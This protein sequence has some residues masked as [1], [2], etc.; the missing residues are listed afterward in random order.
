[1]A[2]FSEDAIPWVLDPNNVAG[3]TLILSFDSFVFWHS[4][5]DRIFIFCSFGK[6]N[7]VRFSQNFCDQIFVEIYEY[8]HL[9]KDTVGEGALIQARALVLKL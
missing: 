4:A 6:T 1:M 3:V 8:M 5:G 9:T 7:F 2:Q